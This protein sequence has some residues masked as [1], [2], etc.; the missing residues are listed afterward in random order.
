[1]K[2]LDKLRLPE[3]LVT[4]TKGWCEA[5]LLASISYYC[6]MLIWRKWAELLALFFYLKGRMT[7]PTGVYTDSHY[8][9]EKKG[10]GTLNNSSMDIIVCAFK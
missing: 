4:D 5:N 3:H 7:T 2:P 1:M 8:E 9:T 10:C 6:F